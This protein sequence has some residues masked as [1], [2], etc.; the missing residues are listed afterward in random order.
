[1]E[2]WGSISIPA[3]VFKSIQALGYTS[4]TPIQTACI[5]PAVKENKDIVGAAETVRCLSLRAHSI[6]T[7]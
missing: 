4:P 1:M 5:P 3:Q 6:A 7:E 2:T